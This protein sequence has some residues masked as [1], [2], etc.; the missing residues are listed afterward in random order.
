[1]GFEE[2]YGLVLIL[3]VGVYGIIIISFTFGLIRA[4]LGRTFDTGKFPIPSKTNQSKSNPHQN[5][6]PPHPQIP[7][8]PHPQIFKL[9]KCNTYKT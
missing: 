1:M 8:S 6:K 2:I 7:T 9:K 3:I 5:P 4:E